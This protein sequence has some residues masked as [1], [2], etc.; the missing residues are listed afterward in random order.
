MFKTYLFKKIFITKDTKNA[1]KAK[2]NKSSLI[3]LPRDNIL[4][5]AINFQYEHNMCNRMEILLC[6]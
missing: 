4:T 3:P 6:I 1:E 2:M 5:V